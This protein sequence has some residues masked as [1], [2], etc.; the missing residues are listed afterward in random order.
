MSSERSAVGAP[1]GSPRRAEQLLLAFL[2]EVLLD[3]EIEEVPAAVLIGLLAEL[4]IGEVATRTTLAR[5]VER[6]LLHKSRSGRQVAFRYTP[7]CERI[8]RDAQVRVLAADPFAPVGSG[9]TLV[10]FSV[11][12]SRRDVR[13]R[14]RATLTWSGFGLLRDGL[15]IAPGI[16]DISAMLGT[17]ATS[18]ASTYRRSGPSRSMGSRRGARS[19][20]RGTST[21]SGHGTWTSSP[22]GARSVSG[23]TPYGT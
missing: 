16:V 14:V 6:G 12:E 2:G 23:P 19:P 5:M 15:W 20:L 18:T 17:L 4:G 8:L 21:R 7:A 22:P 9:W 1:A 11:P 3:G 10:T 13:H